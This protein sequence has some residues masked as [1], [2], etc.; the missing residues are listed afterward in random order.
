MEIA[1][2][3]VVLRSVE[4]QDREML[5]NLVADPEIVKVTGG[6]LPLT[7]G[8]HHMKWFRAMSD[9]AKGLHGIIANR[10]NPRAALGIIILACENCEEGAA[11]IY[12]KLM[13]SA[14]KMGYGEDAVNTLVSYAFREGGFRYIYSNILEDNTASRRLFEKCRFKQEGE[15]KSSICKNGYYKNVCIYGIRR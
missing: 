13:N 9:P 12:I 2:N 1:G 11:E 4:E 14:R 6:Y 3:R 5:T 15:Y 7:S 10:E 8:D